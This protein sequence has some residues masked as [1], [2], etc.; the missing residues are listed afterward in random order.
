[1][2][3]RGISFYALSDLF[4]LNGKMNNF[5]YSQAIKYY[6]NN[7]NEFKKENLYFEQD[8]ARCH[9]SKENKETLN[10]LFRNK[11]I[12]NST[13]SPVFAYPI[14]TLWAELKKK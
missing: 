6:K 9:T 7:F 13:H 11:W 5:A 4:L 1:M 10:K 14:E 3:A 2:I 12:Q 8:G